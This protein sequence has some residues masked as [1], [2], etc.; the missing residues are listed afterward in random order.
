LDFADGLRLVIS[1]EPATPVES[2]EPATTGVPERET[3]FAAAPYILYP[4]ALPTT[5]YRRHCPSLPDSSVRSSA[6]GH[7]AV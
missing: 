5:I 1:P 2:T 3:N 7:S 6:V 4:D